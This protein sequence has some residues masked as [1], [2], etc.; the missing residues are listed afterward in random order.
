ME[1]ILNSLYFRGMLKE[2][3]FKWQRL[4]NEGEC[5]FSVW[6]SCGP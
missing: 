4:H 5:S 2:L 6:Y 1:P 3:W